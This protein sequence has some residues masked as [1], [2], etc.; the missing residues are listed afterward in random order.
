MSA[1]MRPTRFP[2]FASETAML[3]AT[4]D[5]PTPPLPLETAMIF[6]SPG[7]AT[8]VGADGRAPAGGVITGRG[9]RPDVCG[10]CGDCGDGADFA[11]MTLTVA[12]VTP[13]TPSSARRI[14]SASCG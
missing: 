4:V 1:S 11:S 12:S 9:A 3:T 14:A 10:D 7:R 2:D 6:P 5:L 13:S 8:G